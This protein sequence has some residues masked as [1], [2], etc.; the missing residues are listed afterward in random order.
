[1]KFR[2]E[3]LA[4]PLPEDIQKLKWFGDFE[5]EKRIIQK[6]LEKDIPQGLKERLN[7]ELEIIETMPRQY[8]YSW[9]EALKMAGETFEGFTREEFQAL[10]EE[11]AMDWIYVYGR[12]H[13]RD[14]FLSNLI[15]TRSHLAE[16]LINKELAAEH[17]ENA[18]FLDK[19]ISYM[20]ENNGISC[21]FHIR[22][23]LRLKEGAVKTGEKIKVYLPLPVEYAQV[24][25]VVIVDARIIKQDG[26]EYPALL[27]PFSEQEGGEG[28]SE[29]WEESAEQENP[30]F[31]AWTAP[32]D[33]AQRTVCFCGIYQQ[34]MT[35]QIE[36]TYKISMPYID[37]YTKNPARS[38]F[39]KNADIS[40][41]IPERES[42]L[43]KY[44]LGEQLPHIRFT[45][46]LRSLAA[47]IVGKKKN[48]LKKARKIY[49]YVTSHM[50]YSFVRN[51]FSITELVDYGASG[52]KGDCGLQALLFITLC[53]IENIPARWQSGLYT[54]R[55]EAGSHDWAMFYLEPYGWLYADCSFGTSA[56]REGNEKR[57]QFYFGNLDPYRMPS[58][59]QFQADF[60]PPFSGLRQDP[61]D[62]QS[63]EV[64]CTDRALRAE[65]METVHLVVDWECLDGSCFD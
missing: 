43:P 25:D 1:M 15:K 20:K 44:Y 17:R 50:M 46:Y 26:Q 57:R 4:A 65:E 19:T 47:E 48:P 52:W 31:S 41:W 64:E 53:R 24:S 14:N 61:Y 37:L 8:P 28:V 62:N 35:F 33:A 32:S 54:G 18:L 42:D 29:E 34:G 30:P 58:C 38:F 9:E 3:T 5:T 2:E 6:R 63:G 7:A 36:Y 39:V 60:L 45:P 51:Y 56:Y 16:R 40:G 12:V 23:A 13:F 10:W 11:D 27:F 21:R 22:S 55:K 49:E 59:S